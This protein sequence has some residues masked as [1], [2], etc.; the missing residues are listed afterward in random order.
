MKTLLWVVTAI[1]CCIAPMPAAIDLIS[2][3]SWFD[4]LAC[5]CLG[6]LLGAPLAVIAVTIYIAASIER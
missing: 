1:A 2:S 5:A 4:I 3:A 6:G